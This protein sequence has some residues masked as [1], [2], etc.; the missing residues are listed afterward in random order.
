MSCFGVYGTDR[1][2]ASLTYKLATL[3]QIP[4]D[5]SQRQCSYL[6]GIKSIRISTVITDTIN[7]NIFPSL[8]FLLMAY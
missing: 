5:F 1:L 4:T 2:T 3:T 8:Y 7:G 6:G